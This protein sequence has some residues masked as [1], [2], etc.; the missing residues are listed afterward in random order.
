MFTSGCC[1][2]GESSANVAIEEV[3]SRS[4]FHSILLLYSARR[5]L[6]CSFLATSMDRI[7]NP[8]IRLK[9]HYCS[10]SHEINLTASWNF[11]GYFV[12]GILSVSPI[13]KYHG[14]SFESREVGCKV[15][16]DSRARSW[17]GWVPLPVSAIQLIQQA[18]LVFRSFCSALM[19]GVCFDY[20]PQ[21]Y[22]M[23][24]YGGPCVKMALIKLSPRQFVSLWPSLRSKHPV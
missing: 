9:W 2:D 5:R 23:H 4:Y 3:A 16:P 18:V 20:F 21:G 19:E 7:Q 13:A 14:K 15:H 11:K 10:M 22:E 8:G 1:F 6:L 24:F 12:I 17:L